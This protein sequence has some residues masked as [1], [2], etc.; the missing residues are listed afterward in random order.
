MKFVLAVEPDVRQAQPLRRI[1]ARQAGVELILVDA[2]DV[3]AATLTSRVPHLLLLGGSLTERDRALAVDHFILAS[4]AR[5]PQMLAIPLLYDADAEAAGTTAGKGRKRRKPRMP[6]ADPEA[7][8]AEIAICLARAGDVPEPLAAIAPVESISSP[9]VDTRADGEDVAIEIESLADSPDTVDAERHAAELAVLQ[10]Q[11]EARLAAEVERVRHEA[12]QQHAEEL[13]R[14]RSEG[15]ARVL[16]IEEEMARVRAAAARRLAEQIEEF[17]RERTEAEERVRAAAEASATLTLRAEVDRVRT[18]GDAQLEAEI[19]RVREEAEAA[20]ARTLSDETAI[21]RAAADATREAALARAREDFELA[22]AAA[23]T[24]AAQTF[25][26]ELARIRADA[27]ARRDAEIAR[28]N[29]EAEARL[30]TERTRA[31]AA[32]EEARQSDRAARADLE[33]ARVAARDARMAADVAAAHAREADA[34]R[35]ESERRSH[36]E[37]ERVRHEMDRARLSYQSAIEHVRGEA[38]RESRTQAE[39]TIRGEVAR[40]RAD[41]EVR[42]ASAVAAVQTEAEQRRVAGLAAIRAQIDQVTGTT[43]EP[44]VV[45]P[46]SSEP[47]PSEPLRAAIETPLVA[48][49]AAPPAAPQIARQ[50]MQL[51]ARGV[52]GAAR[53]LRKGGDAALP[54]ARQVIER[55]PPRTGPV[56]MVLLLVVGGLAFVDVSALTQ[57]GTSVAW[58][59]SRKAVTILGIGG[60]ASSAASGASASAADGSSTAGRSEASAPPVTSGLLQVFSRVPMDLYIAGRRIGTTGDGQIVLTPGSYRVEFVSTRLN[61]RGEALLSI[62]SAAVTTHNVTL[63]DGSLLIETEPG[64]EITVEGEPAGVAPAGVLRVPLGTRE[65]LV[66]HPDLGERR[67]VVEVRY[68]VTN[69][70]RVA[71]PPR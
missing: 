67:E 47:P 17:E 11:A 35:V 65:V 1:V 70:L 52:R 49:P 55:L 32:L 71:F 2:A 58:S 63:P 61:Y 24:A 42:I 19:R 36:A 15:D 50:A 46:P 53:E 39:L 34:A 23:A 9:I 43:T 68:G 6:V 18:A 37:L 57:R 26:T 41:A 31:T 48:S 22:Q 7:F 45:E 60:T 16:A 21:L 10:A 62:R 64:A 3:A 44:L 40:A 66:R 51:T 25:E 38:E 12:A 8:S 28:V 54:I 30:Q 13:S 14:L 29:A 69:E 56:A 33:S 4:S 20:A 5:E 59:A 27:D